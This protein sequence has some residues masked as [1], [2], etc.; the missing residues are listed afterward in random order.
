VNK[1]KDLKVTV[2]RPKDIEEF[3]RGINELAE[4][5]R[6]AMHLLFDTIEADVQDKER[7]VASQCKTIQDMQAG[8]NKL[9]DYVQVLKFVEL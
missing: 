8:I 6:R 5:K 7:F 1:C 2:N 9:Q 4:D 3:T